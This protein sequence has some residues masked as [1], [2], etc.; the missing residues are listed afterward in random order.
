MVELNK[1]VVTGL[2]QGR[3]H[4][5]LLGEGKWYLPDN[6]FRKSHDI[7]L[8]MFVLLNWINTLS[9]PKPAIDG[10]ASMLASLAV[11]NPWRCA[12][13][14]LAYSI[15]AKDLGISLPIDF[16]PLRAALRINLKNNPPE[17]R[18]PTDTITDLERRMLEI[19]KKR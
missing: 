18:N 1:F 11:A 8:V 12:D 10:L 9:H 2:E 7:M 16:K 19:E 14:L 13:I 6:T 3:L 17:N 4:E 5:L 15:T